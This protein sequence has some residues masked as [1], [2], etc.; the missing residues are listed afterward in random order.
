LAPHLGLV[1]DAVLRLAA[2]AVE[3]PE[4]ADRLRERLRLS[5]EQTAQLERAAVRDPGMGPAASEAA[6]RADLYRQGEEAY[7]ERVLLAWMRSGDPPQSE[8]WRRRMALPGRW[9]TPAFPLGGA[10]VLA[11]GVPAGPRVGEILRALEGEW[12][13]GDFGAD[14]PALRARL[15]ELARAD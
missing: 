5:N 14:A 1:P 11:E 4:D 13:A 10:D 3:V 8:G 6:A 12:I 2:L 9:P 7:R 15:K